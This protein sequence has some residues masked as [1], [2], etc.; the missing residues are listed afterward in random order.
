M[1]LDW[2]DGC[3]AFG[4][5]RIRLLINHEHMCGLDVVV[6]ISALVA[7]KEASAKT[8]VPYQESVIRRG[9]TSA[10]QSASGYAMEGTK[11]QG[12]STSRKARI[13][14][15]LKEEAEAAASS[16]GSSS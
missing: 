6:G 2:M 15:S 7:V 14:A 13:L 9:L 4:T 10:A 16:P 3:S 5:E 8:A 11:K 12:I 1:G